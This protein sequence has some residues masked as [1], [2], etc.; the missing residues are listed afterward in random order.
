MEFELGSNKEAYDRQVQ[1]KESLV[2]ELFRTN[3]EGVIS[4]GQTIKPNNEEIEVTSPLKTKIKDDKKENGE[5][6]LGLSKGK[7]GPSKGKWKKI[8]R[9][10]GKAHDVSMKAQELSVGMKRTETMDTLAKNEG[11]AQKKFCE[12]EGRYKEKNVE[13]TAV[14]ARQHH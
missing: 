7:I 13:E 11:R 1:I 10:I 5:V 14:V 6:E 12:C 3:E 4:V 8:A 2:K 9:E